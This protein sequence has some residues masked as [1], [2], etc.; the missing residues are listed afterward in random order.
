MTLKV[1][2]SD[3]DGTLVESVGIKDAAFHALY[4]SEAPERLDEIMAYHKA[5]NATLRFEK[6]RYIHTEILRQPYDEAE[7]A[8]LSQRF[9]EFVFD[10]I[11]AAPAVIGLEELLETVRGLP[12]YL[13]S[14]SPDEELARILTARQLDRHLAGVY[15]GSWSKPA[16]LQDILDREQVMAEEAVYLGDTE[17]DRAAAE[18]VGLSFI[19][20]DSGRPISGAWPVFS[21]L[22]G[23]VG[24]LKALQAV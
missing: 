4:S 8:R 3:F 7:R 13:V 21:D 9:S 12:L 14:M 22:T 24:H 19:G 18:A 15:P 16:A 20:R 17:E 6:F 23:I 5:H 1:V 2:I 10:R 11:V